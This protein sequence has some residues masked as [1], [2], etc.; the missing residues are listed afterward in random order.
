MT[1]TTGA[2]LQ[3]PEW[4]ED[5]NIAILV[6]RNLEHL[7]FIILKKVQRLLLSILI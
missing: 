2:G 3:D 1:I 5:P 4:P 7:S 6:L